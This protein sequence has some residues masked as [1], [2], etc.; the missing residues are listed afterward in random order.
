MADAWEKEHGLDPG[1]A[2]DRN[3]IGPDGRTMLERYL[4]FPAKDG[5]EP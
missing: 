4:S 3:R 5:T 1:S 2:D